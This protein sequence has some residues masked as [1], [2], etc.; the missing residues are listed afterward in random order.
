VDFW[1][2]FSFSLFLLKNL[3]K[4]WKSMSIIYCDGVI[5][6]A[7]TG[8]CIS[9]AK[10]CIQSFSLAGSDF[11][12][13]SGCPGESAQSYNETGH[14]SMQ[15]PSPVQT[16]Q[17]TALVVPCM[18]SFRGGSTGPQTLWPLCSPI[19]FRFVWKSGSIGKKSP[20]GIR[21]AQ[22]INFSA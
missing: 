21:K 15:T 3:E 17:S 4:F 2:F 11:R 5:F 7:C 6:I 19:T 8:H 10:H 16:S 20:N 14:T 12:S 22:D 9:H 18:P 13:E 1:L